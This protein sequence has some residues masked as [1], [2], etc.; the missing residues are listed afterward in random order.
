MI[1][2]SRHPFFFFYAHTSYHCYLLSRLIAIPTPLQKDNFPYLISSF[3]ASIGF[4]HNLVVQFPDS[5]PSIPHIRF[6]QNPFPI[7]QFSL[8][9]EICRQ[10]VGLLVSFLEQQRWEREQS[11]QGIKGPNV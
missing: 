5:Q 8:K 7:S 11:Y 9:L 1:T 6:L 4:L 3:T 2:S 10:V